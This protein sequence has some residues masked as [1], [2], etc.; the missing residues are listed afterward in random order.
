MHSKHRHGRPSRSPSGRC[1]STKRQDG[2]RTV[3][4]KGSGLMVMVMVCGAAMTESGLYFTPEYLGGVVSTAA[5]FWYPVGEPLARGAV[6]SSVTSTP[7]AA[8]A[9]TVQPTSDLV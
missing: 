7:A 5:G 1:P 4:L 9:H 6:E 2:S 8:G 3:A